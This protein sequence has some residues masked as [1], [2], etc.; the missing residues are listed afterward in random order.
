MMEIVECQPDPRRAIFGFRDTGYSLN[1]AVADI[2]DNSI[3]A[4]ANNVW[5]IL[6]KRPDNQLYARIIDDG[7]GMDRDGLFSAMKYGSPEQALKNSLG[8]FGLGLKTASTSICKRLTLITRRSKTSNTY[9][10]C[11]D[12]DLVSDEGK[13]CL[14]IGDAAGEYLDEFNKYVTNSGTMVC[15]DVIDRLGTRE[16]LDRRGISQQVLR[17][18]DRSLQSHLTL[19]YHRYMESGALTISLNGEKIEQWNPFLPAENTQHVLTRKFNIQLPGSKIKYPVTLNAYVIPNKYEYSTEDARKQSRLSNKTQGFY[20][21]RED[22]VIISGDWLDIYAQEPHLSLLRVELS[23]PRELDE[24][25]K[26]DIKKSAL[27]INPGLMQMIERE[28]D[29]TRRIA[30][31]RYRQGKRKDGDKETS[32]HDQSQKLLNNKYDDTTENIVVKQIKENQVEI[33][34]ANGTT[35]VTMPTIKTTNFK[36]LVEIV[37]SLDEGLFW[38]P[39]LINNRLGVRINKSHVYYERVYVPNLTDAVTVC[40]IDSVLWALAKCEYEVMSDD[41][42]KKLTDLR[43]NISRTLRELASELPEVPDTED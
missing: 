15:W 43:Y 34:N 21:Y 18:Y 35:I 13:W 42:R 2:I 3:N 28:I 41:I 12:L 14:Q 6:D 22:R 7:Y 29:P 5:V 30:D 4:R 11:W 16:D 26:L 37:D 20:V 32:A 38:E 8:R 25:F 10:A 19:V 1:T 27:D 9:Q 40:G 31:K 24:V 17:T 33:T 39:A 23:F 36:D